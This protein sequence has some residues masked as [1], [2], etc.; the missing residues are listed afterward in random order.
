VDLASIAKVRAN[1]TA[2][3][4][5]AFGSKL[6]STPTIGWRTLNTGTIDPFMNFWDSKPL[7]HQ[8]RMYAEPI[9]PKGLQNISSGRRQLY[10]SPKIIIAKMALRFEG[11]VD[12]LGTYAALNCNCI[13]FPSDGWTLY[14]LASILHSSSVAFIY[15]QFFDGLRMSGG[16]LPFQA[17]QLKTIPIP[18][19][20]C[21]KKL[22]L[23]K[24]G[25]LSAN[26][27]GYRENGRAIQF[28]EE[29]ID[30]CV[31]EIY[32][33]NHMAERDLLFHSDVAVLFAN[34][35][36]KASGEK[37]YEFLCYFYKVANAADHP[38]HNRLMRIP[39]DSPDL[40]GVI[41][42]EMKV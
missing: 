14:A 25:R 6:D 34:Y 20:I 21:E 12:D 26:L 42:Q 32:L 8:G 4:A 40:L 1:T 37:Q 7:R 38:I 31:M 18:K 28:L 15:K 10:N 35:D 29:V 3:E 5:D 22:V 30:A 11:F 27:A 41:Q 36:H 2:A 23:D 13:S 39:I 9:I 24:L 17:P 33:P 16:Y 19:T